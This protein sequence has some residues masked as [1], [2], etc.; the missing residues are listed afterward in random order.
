[1]QLTSECRLL[2]QRLRGC[3]LEE[4]CTNPSLMLK[5]YPIRDPDNEATVFDEIYCIL[6]E[7]LMKKSYKFRVFFFLN[8][9]LSSTKVPAYIIA[10]YIKKL[11]RLSLGAKPRTLVAILRL[12]NNLF[13]RHPVLMF[14]RNR[15][16]D[17]ARVLELHSNTCTLRQWLE[18]DPF[19]PSQVAD[20]KRT[21]AMD[22]CIWELMPLR[23]HEHRK[24]SEAASFLGESSPPDI[25]CDLEDL[26]VR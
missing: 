23:F 15:V 20:L 12:V 17:K 3:D 5:Y 8:I 10:A 9:F 14:L 24:V 7:N 2:V 21:N 25:E 6:N 16:D 11:A 26:L 13:M 18:K 19:D 22:T 4:I 1:M